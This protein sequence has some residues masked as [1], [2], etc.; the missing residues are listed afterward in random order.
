[1]S[2]SRRSTKRRVLIASFL[3]PR[4]VEFKWDVIEA[5]LNSPVRRGSPTPA[6]E[7]NTEAL[8]E[9][10]SSSLKVEVDKE[11]AMARVF[12]NRGL[13]VGT[14]PSMSR[15]SSTVV[16]R[17][18]INMAELMA[19]ATRGDGMYATHAT[20]SALDSGISS[21]VADPENEMRENPSSAPARIMSKTVKNSWS[22]HG[23]HALAGDE[24]EGVRSGMISPRALQTPIH[25]KGASSLT[26]NA[27]PKPPGTQHTD[28]NTPV[29]IISDLA[30]K[31][32]Q[33]RVASPTVQE[34]PLVRTGSVSATIAPPSRAPARTATPRLVS[35]TPL[36]AD[37][38]GKSDH[39]RSATEYEHLAASAKLGTGSQVE[40]ARP[41]AELVK[42]AVAK[43]T[44]KHN[45]P[46]RPR[47]MRNASTRSMTHDDN[48][49]R[50][51]NIARRT[52]KYESCID[53]VEE[54]QH[55]QESMPFDFHPNPGA[56]YGLINA[57]SSTKELDNESVLYIGTLGIEMDWI[58][59]PTRQEIDA[60]S[61]SQE[62]M[63]PVWLKDADYV[64]SYHTYCKQVLWPTFHYTLPTGKGLE[65]ESEAWNA[66]VETN[67][68]FAERIAAEYR[69]G[70]VVWVHD[71]HLLLVPEM[72]RKLIPRAPIGFFLHIAFPSSEIFRCLSRREPLL[73]GMLGSDLIG[74]QTHNFCRHFRQTAN[75]IL[76]AETTARGVH[77]K[78]SFVTV[79]SYPIGIDVKMLQKRQEHPDVTEWVEKLR[80]RFAGMKV[81]VGRDKLDWI[82]G[83]REKLI[84]YEVFLERHP[85]WVG[86]VVLVQVALAT[87]RENSEVVAVSDLVARINHKHGSLTYQPIV[88]LHVQ[89]ITFSQYLALLTMA[90]A[91]LIMSL[92]EGMNLTSH[93][94][95]VA[96]QRR[97]RP[98]ILSEF[99]GTYSALRACIGVNPFNAQQVAKAIHHALMMPEEEMVRRWRDLHHT[100]MSQSSHHWVAS[101]LSQLERVHLQQPYMETM[102]KPELEIAQMQS[103]WRA[104][105][106]CLVLLDL[107]GTLM[108]EDLCY[109]HGNGFEPPH[110]I[111][112]LL[113]RLVADHR[114]YVYLLS[115]HSRTD[116]E[117]LAMEV[118]YLGLV[119]EDGC[120]VRHCMAGTRCDWTSLVD[121]FDM[122]WRKPV[123]EILDYFTERTPG[124]WIEERSTTI[125]WYFGEGMSEA[126]AIWARR[127]A[128]EVQGLISDSLGERFSLRI[129]NGQTYFVI[130]PKNVGRSTAVQYMLALDNMG[131]LP[132][133]HAPTNKGRFEFILHIGRDERLIA[134]LNDLDL[135]FAP[136]TCTTAESDSIVS[137]IATS[138]LRPYEQVMDALEDIID[139]HLRDLKWGGPATM[140]I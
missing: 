87:V 7:P 57:V 114:M 96:Q 81:I 90:D 95:I 122:Q 102:F 139:F 67:R 110:A 6:A 39:S 21:P 52:S 100:V 20:E 136:R 131:Q 55:A 37:W 138:Q 120:Y 33:S 38:S 97:Q 127:Q 113:Q 66:Y 3:L 5:S 134:L 78:N 71:Y 101:I 94:Y 11:E 15:R 44:Q 135:P 24:K 132:T 121:G 35:H 88:F 79:A 89:E 91:F 74:F 83:V 116:L 68:R 63:L 73:L 2:K 130:M 137:S 13:H 77:M 92:R 8:A 51:A 133:R 124:S 53:M 64:M 31:Q 86:R 34:H 56:N 46:S 70:D 45:E 128:S 12:P 1:M 109:V 111:H 32:Q 126:D 105:K 82:K 123:R 99:T 80:E 58:P 19:D 25:I 41:K 30:A 108:R 76:Q 42:A 104:S 9:A 107:E 61:K 47:P 93:E 14:S 115:S 48:S 26:G 23:R 117:K 49:Q 118:P 28:S 103:E 72:L 54:P 16:S 27:T 125:A 43:A 10:L 22:D 65:N 17:D 112:R 106:S 18:R 59:T 60:V 140:D 40:M 84:A 50:Y 129:V 119:A 4:T 62:Q 98:L 29:S 36:V 69:D 85:E 75:R